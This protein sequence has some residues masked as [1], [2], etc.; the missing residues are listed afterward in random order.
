M[1]KES[2]PRR[3]AIC[4]AICAAE[5]KATIYDAGQRYKDPPDARNACRQALIT[6]IFAVKQV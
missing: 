5:V 4:D 1:A 6:A 3:R 2:D